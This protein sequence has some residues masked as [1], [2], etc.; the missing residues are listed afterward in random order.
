MPYITPDQRE[1]RVIPDSGNL[2]FKIT[3]L[4]VQY[5]DEHGRNY[6]TFNDI[7]GAL[8]AAKMEFNRRIVVPYEDQKIEDNGDVY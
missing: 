8:E 6:K 2:N 1:Y 3:S 5:L 7:I 4:I